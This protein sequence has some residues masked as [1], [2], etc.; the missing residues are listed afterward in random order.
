MAIQHTG[1]ILGVDYGDVRTGLA[2]S[3]PT[4]FLASGLMTVKGGGMHHTAVFVA[5]EAK[6]QNAVRIVVGYPKNMDGSEGFRAETV[7]SFVALLQKET[8][9]PVELF[10]ERL[11]TVVAHTY[12][13]LSESKKRK[14]KVDTL[15]AEIILQNYLDR[16]KNIS[17]K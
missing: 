14:E 9:L 4:G 2:I 13:S 11:T 10:D 7:K 6:K 17:S 3:D 5:E 8:S 1:K 15:S 12:L 16:M